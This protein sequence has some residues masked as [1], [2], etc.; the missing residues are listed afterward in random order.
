LK[1]FSG[2]QGQRASCLPEEV[3]ISLRQQGLLLDG[4]RNRNKIGKDKRDGVLL[5]SDFCR[6]VVIKNFL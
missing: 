3:V 6:E 5:S 2:C 1:G 4:E